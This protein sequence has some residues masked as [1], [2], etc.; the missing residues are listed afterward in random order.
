MNLTT[1]ALS[2]L[3]D[4]IPR[5]HTSDN[6]KEMIS[7]FTD[8]EDLLL[9]IEAENAFYESNIATFF[10][11]LEMARSALKKST[12]NK[13]SKKNKD[14]YFDETAGI[15]KDSI[16]ELIELYDDGKKAT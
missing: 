1:T 16:Q 5:R 6:V 7:I 4:K 8:Y 3:F 15:I 13:A 11:Q 10:D 2:A 14:V 9:L 12:D